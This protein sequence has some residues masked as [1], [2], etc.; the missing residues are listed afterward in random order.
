MLIGS[1]S[2]FICFC[3]VLVEIFAAESRSGQEMNLVMFDDT[4]SDPLAVCNDGT[5]G[6]YYFA[7]AIDPSQA[8]TFVV[9]LPG[10]GQCY[11]KQSCDERPMDYKSSKYFTPSIY[12]EGIMD[13][14]SSKTPLWGANKAYLGYCSSDGYMGDAPASDETWGYHFR[15]QRLVQSMFQALIKTH[16]FNN[17][18]TVY[19]VGSSAGARGM[20]VHSDELIPAYVP[21]GATV[22]AYLDSPY[23]LDIEPYSSAFQGFQYQEQQ[24]YKYYNTQA[25]LSADC[26]AAYPVEEQW[27][28]QYG[29][30]R[31]PFVKVPY[32]LVASQYDAYQLEGDTQLQP[33]QYS[34]STTEYA[35]SFAAHDRMCLQS[36]SLTVGNDSSTTAAT[37]HNGTPHLRGRASRRTRSAIPWSSKGAHHR[38]GGAS[39]QH[40]HLLH[41]A[42]TAAN[43]N[44][45]HTGSSLQTEEASTSAAATVQHAGGYA[46]YA[47]ACYNHAVASSDKFYTIAT[48]DGTTQKAAFE[49]YL[50]RNPADVSAGTSWTMAWQDECT[51]FNCGQHC[52]V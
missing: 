27:K 47:W 41:T 25:I 46:F 26:I 8:N 52:E 32:F 35:E 1:T 44:D 13:K 48:S 40:P 37:A 51:T 23:Y 17:A 6:G 3:F 14:D 50:S 30:Y 11:D 21:A 42:A 18:T 5:R 29:E 4:N 45:R 9:Y 2:L 19:F 33:E 10:G 24:K 22:I 12:V 20:M 36:L 38:E 28:C 15:G 39:P 16:G 49:A 7:S 34:A 43:P 31:M